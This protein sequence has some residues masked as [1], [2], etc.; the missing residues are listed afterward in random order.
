MS[1]R[2]L[3]GPSGCGKSHSLYE[4]LVKEASENPKTSYIFIVP[5]QF[6]LSTEK[7]LVEKSSGMGIMNIEVLSFTRLAYRIME[8]AG[9]A[10]YPLI[11]DMGKSMLIRKVMQEEKDRLV[12]YAGKEKSAGFLDEVKS[13]ISEF[14]QYLITPKTLKTSIENSTGILSV[15][16]N[17]V[18]I[19]YEG[20]LKK[21]EGLFSTS[22]SLLGLCYRHVGNSGFLK[23]SVIVFDGFTGFTPCQSEFVEH[24]MPY[25]K[26]AYICATIDDEY[27]SE[28]NT[29]DG[30][31]IKVNTDAGIFSMSA[32]MLDDIV[33]LGEKNGHN[34]EIYD[35]D[36]FCKHE[37][38]IRFLRDNIFRYPSGTYKN[39][40]KTCITAHQNRKQEALYIAAR[41]SDLLRDEGLKYDE[42]AVMSGDLEGYAPYFEKAF[43]DYGINCHIDDSKNISSN[44]L[45]N[46]ITGILKVAEGDFRVDD[47]IEH[48][49]SPL[50]GFEETDV[51]E[52]ENYLICYGYRGKK[53]YQ[54]NWEAHKK[55]KRKI[56]L[57]NI[58]LVRETLFNRFIPL[59]ESKSSLNVSRIIEL[60]YNQLV[61]LDIRLKLSNL[62]EIIADNE[63]ND[64]LIKEYER[65]YDAVIAIFKQMYDLMGDEQCTFKEFLDIFMTGVRKTKLGI[66]PPNK[67]VVLVGDLWRT[68]IKDIKVLFVAG[69]NDGVIPRASTQSGLLT[70]DERERLKS[71]GHKLAPGIKEKPLNEEYYVYLALS[72]PS[73]K[74]YV[75]YSLTQENGGEIKQSYVINILEVLLGKESELYNGK[76]LSDII[77]YDKGLSYVLDGLKVENNKEDKL[78]GALLK[79]LDEGKVPKLEMIK[80]INDDY[81][82]RGSLTSLSARTADKLY[83]HILISSVSRI[84]TFAGCAYRHFLR[85]GLGLD[86][87]TQSEADNMDFGNLFHDALKR[88]GLLVKESGNNWKDFTDEICE[89]SAKECFYEALNSYKDGLYVGDAAKEHLSKRM[90]KVMVTTAKALVKQIQAGDYEPYL[91]EYAFNIPGRF[92]N[93]SGKIDR[94][95]IYRENGKTYLKIL[96]YKTGGSTIDYVKLYYGLQLQLMVYMNSMVNSD[97]FKDSIPAAVLYQEVTDPSLEEPKDIEREKLLSLRPSGVIPGGI[98][99]IAHFDRGFVND[100]GEAVAS[101]NS[102]VIGAKTL[103]S[104]AVTTSG[105]GNMLTETDIISSLGS[106]AGK[107]VNE[108]SKEIMN[109]EIKINPY[110]SGMETACDYCDYKGVCGFDK[111]N[112]AYKYNKLTIDADEALDNMVNKNE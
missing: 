25:I 11:N 55:L 89:V 6:A 1:I 37:E 46:Y 9:D 112:K 90:E 86:K 60:I 104:G 49:K 80:R 53:R 39:T 72:K 4:M 78:L 105:S 5:E 57:E 93:L 97:K 108:L 98:N 76:L 36:K 17:D 71:K 75:S 2:L 95:D 33:R 59:T 67:D 69:M 79:L 84:E 88:F 85:Y 45:V 19:I 47:I 23:D 92:T 15:K 13:I 8:E 63:D 10:G 61:D 40:T 106:Y 14:S 109:G 54:S 101:Y 62:A 28:T 44:P 82:T 50:S 110:K 56:N 35:Y 58:N 34:S 65:V 7:E 66:L 38:E 68:R 41:I 12:L 64:E 18:A 99:E 32:T 107:M 48:I 96:D 73:K 22:E 77:G 26:D 3:T 83:N 74:L 29:P 42:I 87:R 16:L 81:Y 111:K 70:D 103:K 27:I 21:I 31:F 100:K 30:G 51:Y 91:Y 20:F 24:I 94:I 102:T 52:F 43:K